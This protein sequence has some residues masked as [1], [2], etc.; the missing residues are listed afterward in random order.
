MMHT[1]KVFCLGML[2]AGSAVAFSVGVDLM[3]GWW[4]FVCLII[5]SFCVF[6]ISFF[7]LKEYFE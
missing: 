2:T 1:I 3:P 5:P 7:E 4:E 6:I